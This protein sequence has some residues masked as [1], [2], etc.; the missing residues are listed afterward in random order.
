MAAGLQQMLLSQFVDANGDRW[1]VQNIGIVLSDGLDGGDDSWA[2]LAQGSAARDAG[3]VVYSIGIQGGL[4]ASMLAGISSLPQQVQ[5]SYYQTNLS[6]L[7]GLADPV[8]ARVCASSAESDCTT[9]VSHR[10]WEI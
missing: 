4:N 3:V 10:G 2:A 9:K 7:N 1:G 5:P 8:V 6:Q